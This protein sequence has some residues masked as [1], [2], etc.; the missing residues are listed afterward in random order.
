MDF[1][2]ITLNQLSKITARN[3][4]IASKHGLILSWKFIDSKN[5]LAQICSSD[6]LVEKNRFP[7]DKD[8]PF[9]IA[10]I[11]YW[12]TEQL[13]AT[14]ELFD[15]KPTVIDTR[16]KKWKKGEGFRPVE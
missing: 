7:I 5:I 8:L 12:F 11:Q 16:E 2:N 9:I 4:Y 14:E 13:K 15:V 1:G 10:E 6:R 3:N